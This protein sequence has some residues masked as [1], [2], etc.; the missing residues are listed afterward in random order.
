VATGVAADLQDLLAARVPCRAEALDALVGGDSVVVEADARS[1]CGTG[2]RFSAMAV[3]LVVSFS[4]S[5]Q[6]ARCSKPT[7]GGENS[8]EA[9]VNLG[10]ICGGT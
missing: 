3:C 8:Y 2:A 5:V 1:S 10:S 7:T 6:L 4:L 9:V